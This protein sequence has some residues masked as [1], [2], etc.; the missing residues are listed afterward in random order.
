MV[1]EAPLV[2]LRIYSL[3]SLLGPLRLSRTVRITEP[4]CYKTESDC[5]FYS[6]LNQYL[7]EKLHND[8][9]LMFI[10]QT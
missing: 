4:N 7:K 1:R 10:L 2:I 3:Y 8:S 6:S 9:L 5:F